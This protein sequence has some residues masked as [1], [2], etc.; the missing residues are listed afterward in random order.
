MESYINWLKNC[1]HNISNIKLDGMS[2][3]GE[4]LLWQ[5]AFI[6]T[7]AGT[8]AII[9][10]A[11]YMIVFFPRKVIKLNLSKIRSEFNALVEK[12]HAY[13]ELGE[14]EG[15]KCYYV[16]RNYCFMTEIEDKYEK[17]MTIEL[18]SY[19]FV[20]LF[21]LM[22]II[23][24]NVF[25]I[26]VLV[27][28][29]IAFSFMNFLAFITDEDFIGIRRLVEYKIR[30]ARDE[31][32]KVEED[33]IDFPYTMYNVYALDDTYVNKIIICRDDNNAALKE[34]HEEFEK[35]NDYKE[36]FRFTP[37]EDS[38]QWNIEAARASFEYV[39]TRYDEIKLSHKEREKH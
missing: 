23:M 16:R 4:A 32:K 17:R 31:Y 26:S 34:L 36:R 8:V 20:A 10:L 5:L 38:S 39:K 22:P 7:I 35:N 18:Y 6:G 15:K 33:D 30:K 2:S 25:T 9:A 1:V 12:T 29:V 19:L 28:I 37:K 13:V 14:I 11:I 21:L 27:T 3:Y 24:T